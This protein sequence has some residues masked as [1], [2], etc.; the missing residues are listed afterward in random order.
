MGINPVLRD[1]D[2][3][4]KDKVLVVKKFDKKTGG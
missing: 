1:V 2:I 4:V 3:E